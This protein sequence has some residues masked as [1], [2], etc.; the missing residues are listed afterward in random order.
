MSCSSLNGTDAEVLRRISDALRVPINARSVLDQMAKQARSKLLLA[1]RAEDEL[2]AKLVL[3]VGED[4]LR[5][6]LPRTAIDDLETG[7]AR[8]LG[9][10]RAGRVVAVGLR[11]PRA[12]RIRSGARRAGLE[13]PEAWAGSRDARQY[14]ESLGFPSRVRRLPGSQPV[15]PRLDVEGPVELKPLHDFQEK[16]RRANPR[17][18]HAAPAPRGAEW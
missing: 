15:A 2:A 6:R 17:D 16:S 12:Q 10:Y 1:I 7:E 9:A 8:P 14:V 3:A 18:A 5:A 4:V 11:L 13:P